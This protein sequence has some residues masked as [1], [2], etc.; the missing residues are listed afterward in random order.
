MPIKFRKNIYVKDGS[1]VLTEPIP[2]GKKVKGEIV[3]I[4]STDQIKYYKSQGL[5]PEVF[6]NA[7]DNT[8]DKC[9]IA[10]PTERSNIHSLAKSSFDSSE[11]ESTDDESD[12]M[13][14]LNAK[15]ISRYVFSADEDSDSDGDASNDSSDEQDEEEEGKNT[16]NY[17]EENW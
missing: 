8:S 3:K 13:P 15:A 6:V 17:G 14:N 12:L 4:V 9:P 5:W 1:Y 16:K 2:E 11:D 7:L 10:G